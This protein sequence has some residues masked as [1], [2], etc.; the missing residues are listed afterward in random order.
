MK[1]TVI[2][3]SVLL[4]AGL[5]GWRAYQK[6][7]AKGQPQ[8]RGARGGAVA[9]VLQ[10]V[11]RDTIRDVR[12]FTGTVYPK[13]QFV[14]A[15]KIPGRLERLMVNTGSKVRNGDPIAVLDDQEYNRL[16][17]QAQAELE[18]ANANVMDTRSA[19]EI[20]KRE[21][22]RAQEL[23][24]EKVASEAELDQVD[25]RYKAAQ[26]KQE[27]AMAQVKQREAALKANQV[28][29]SY[30]RINASWEDSNSVRVVGERFVDEGAMLRAN[31]PIV[32]ILDIN[33][34]IATIFVIE[35]DYPH[36]LA[37]QT[38]TVTTDA[39]PG[40]NFSGKVARK[41]PF[42]RESSRQARVEIEI[43]NPEYLLAPGMF[44]RAEIQFAVRENATI[45]PVAAVVRR[46]A[47][48]GVF[49]ADPTQAKAR[50]VPITQG[51]VSGESTEV[52]APPLDGQVVVLGQHLLEDGAAIGVPDA[53]PKAG[54]AGPAPETGTATRDPGK[55]G[56][57]RP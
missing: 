37:G 55:G 53:G 19:V 50:F 43:Q 12:V 26:A 13:E 57:G 24:K 10:P 54:A 47:Q 22:E 31:D 25:A 46:N 44:V 40:K 9:V 29:L 56:G 32:S 17:E 41:A 28:R 42:L 11:R 23:R 52:L 27:V 21:F 7:S 5:I 34:V 6:V 38:A 45:V 48:V 15:P 33:T 35:R 20:A 14:L 1:K 49:L 36:V 30:T 2:I 3:L 51:I 4:L 39:F 8:R 16:V 18:V